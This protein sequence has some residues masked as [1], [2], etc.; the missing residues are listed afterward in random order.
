MSAFDNSVAEYHTS[1]LGEEDEISPPK[2]P[3][4]RRNDDYEMNVLHEMSDN[5]NPLQ[6]D[7]DLPID[8]VRLLPTRQA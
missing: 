1:N 2:T 7:G 8:A 5:Q 4:Y 3:D 6:D